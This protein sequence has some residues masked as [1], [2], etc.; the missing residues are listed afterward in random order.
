M[1]QTRILHK[2]ALILFGILLC[3]VLLESGLRLAGSVFLLRQHLVNRLT[4]AKDDAVRILCIGES[5]TALGD[6][7][8]YPRQ[9]EKILNERST[10]HRFAVIN[11]GV[12]GTNSGEILANVRG[13][14][15]A[16]RPHLVLVMMGINDRE[17]IDRLTTPARGVRPW[18]E[19]L[20]TVHLIRWITA[21]MRER[22]F[23]KE[24]EAAL[25]EPEADPARL[26][27]MAEY[28]RERRR[29][30]TAERLLKRAVTLQPD[31]GPLLM[32][33]ADFYWDRERYDDVAAVLA[34]A[35]DLD[36]RYEHWLQIADYYRRLEKPEESEKACRKAVE[37]R[38]RDEDAFVRL[39][40][41]RLDA[42][43]PAG[44]REVME[45]FWP[46]APPLDDGQFDLAV[47]AYLD[48]EEDIARAILADPVDP[49]TDD[50]QA[51]ETLADRYWDLGRRE[52]AGEIFALVRKLQPEN[53]QANTR[54]LQLRAYRKQS[55]AADKMLYH[56]WKNP[57]AN[58]DFL[59][60]YAAVFDVPAVP[61]APRGQSLPDSAETMYTDH[62]RRNFRQLADLL[63][64]RN[65][66]LAVMQYPMRA[67]EPL[68]RILD[69]A[70]DIIFI[71]N[72]EVFQ[73]AVRDKGYA[74]NFTDLFAGDFGHCTPD[75]NRLLAGNAADHI[76]PEFP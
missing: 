70:E 38:P 44:A 25:N 59:K 39:A 45:T 65:I 75:G 17:Q 36:M 72:E 33:V 12:P 73:E 13:Y 52:T 21:G 19:S 42:G 11:K 46:V 26:V 63:R 55:A 14:L 9:L 51:L 35:A 57:R 16:Y 6:E 47:Y 61:D 71:S 1:A 34:K 43:D 67:V 64:E 50:P 48:G 20:R 32:E 37:Q 54:L 15:D 24:V 60:I 68:H 62:T 10:A 76:L 18:A 23:M 7:F 40:A 3:F 29:F 53:V 8:A 56:L 4:L 2:T 27:R 49:D 5:T 22:Q 30:D 74:A 31:Y 66:R 58:Q 28:F 41:L 69:D